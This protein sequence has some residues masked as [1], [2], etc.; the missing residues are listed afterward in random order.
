MWG[1]KC[2]IMVEVASFEDEIKFGYLVFLEKYFLFYYSFNI[3]LLT[4]NILMDTSTSQRPRFG[5]YFLSQV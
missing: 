3:E 1:M 4:S 2:L 5:F